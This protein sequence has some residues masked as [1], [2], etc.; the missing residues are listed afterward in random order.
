MQVNLAVGADYDWCINRMQ[1][2]CRPFGT[3]I[4]EKGEVINVE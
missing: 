3:V 2:L 1:Q 4:S